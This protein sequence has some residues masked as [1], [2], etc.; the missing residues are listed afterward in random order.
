M[1]INV[2]NVIKNF[3]GIMDNKEILSV[4]FG[5]GHSGW[6][7]NDL[8]F[9]N[10]AINA[11]DGMVMVKVAFSNSYGDVVKS[12]KKESSV[13]TEASQGQQD[14]VDPTQ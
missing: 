3:G 1:K 14:E 11:L 5:F 2:Y 6:S 4:S 13:N 8:H 12:E 9:G 7:N 10:H